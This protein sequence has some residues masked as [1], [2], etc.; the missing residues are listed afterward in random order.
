M[1][2]LHDDEPAVTGA[3]RRVL[4]RVAD[5]ETFNDADT[6]LARIQQAPPDLFITDQNHPGMPGVEMIQSIRR[7]TLGRGLQIWLLTADVRATNGA[8][9]AG[10]DLTFLKPQAMDL[11]MRH[12]SRVLQTKMIELVDADVET[13]DLD[14]KERPDF[15]TK[16]AIAALAKDVIAMANFGGGH[17]IFGKRDLGGHGFET[18]GLTDDEIESLEVTRLNRTLAPFIDPSHT[19]EPSHVIVRGGRKLIDVRV[20]PGA[21]VVFAAKENERARLYLGRIYVRT[22]AAES[23]AA[24]TADQVRRILDRVRPRQ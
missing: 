16:E 14:Y 8:L 3:F 1:I 6:A 15:S 11:F 24:S 4:S 10:A 20:P 7:T 5:V 2:Y 22:G 18:I 17:I 21:D 19:V 23:V 13:A 12:V 9:D